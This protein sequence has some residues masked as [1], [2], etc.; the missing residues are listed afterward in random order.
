MAESIFNVHLVEFSSKQIHIRAF[1]MEGDI[2]DE[3]MI[4]ADLESFLL[5]MIPACSLSMNQL[6]VKKLNN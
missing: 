3:F 1:G 5:V 2:L 6:S 4:P